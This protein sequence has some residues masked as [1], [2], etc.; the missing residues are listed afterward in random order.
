[1]LTAR[2]TIDA[3]R[4]RP[5]GTRE[6]LPGAMPFRFSAKRRGL[7]P[8]FCCYCVSFD[9]LRLKVFVRKFSLS[10]RKQELYVPLIGG[11]HQRK[12]L[13]LAHAAG[14]LGAEQ[15]TLPRMHAKNFAGGGNLEAFFCAPVSLQLHFG[16]GSIPWHL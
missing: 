10:V 7:A 4:Y 5:A 14:F 6:A 13:E 16:L 8:D 3:A 12:L 2:R 1:V 15:V 9:N 11:A